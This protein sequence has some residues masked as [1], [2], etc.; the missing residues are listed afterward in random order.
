MRT[1]PTRAM[2]V[3][4]CLPS[5]DIYLGE[6]AHSAMARFKSVG[7][8]EARSLGNEAGCGIY[9][10]SL[11]IQCKWAMVG[12]ASVVQTE[13][14]GITIVA[15]EIVRRQPTGKTIRIYTD[16]R[17]SLLALRSCKII[18]AAVW[19]FY[20]FNCLIYINVLAEFSYSCSTTQPGQTHTQTTSQHPFPATLPSAAAETRT[21]DR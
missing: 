9:S 21:Q 15:K 7:C 17:Q 16:C 2:E 12:R 3:M 14:A 8:G 1:T 13:L 19:E 5:L 6:V 18:S 11:Q 10:R 4:L 20:L